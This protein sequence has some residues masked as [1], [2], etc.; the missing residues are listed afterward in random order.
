MARDARVATRSG[1]WYAWAASTH[2][3]VPCKGCHGTSLSADLR[4]HLKNAQRVWLHAAGQSPEQI[5][6][7]HRDVMALVDRCRSCHAQEYGDWKRGPHG[8]GY[9]AIFLDPT[10]NRNQQLMDDCF[11]CHGMHYEGGITRLVAPVDRKG[12]WRLTDARMA[13]EPAIP[14][15]ACHQ[16]HR[17]GKPLGPHVTPSRRPSTGEEINR[18]SLALYDR[19]SLD[20]V[21]VADLPLPAMHDGARGVH[22]SPDQ[23]QALCYQCHAPRAE[24][25]V[26]SGDDRTPTRTSTRG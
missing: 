8:V 15:L 4:M 6:I 24:A 26:F 18:P 17:E 16:V 12:P 14:C 20:H 2:R 5:H 9:A 1:R 19:R 7:R 13:D 3:T 10:H 25:Q 21:A 22:V 23:R 11:R